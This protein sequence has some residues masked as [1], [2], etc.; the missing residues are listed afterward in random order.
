M[1]ALGPCNSDSGD[2]DIPL[3]VPQA[4]KMELLQK[5]RCGLVE[6]IVYVDINSKVIT[7]T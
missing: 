1:Y 7:G 5:S 6:P 3:L 2:L 4:N